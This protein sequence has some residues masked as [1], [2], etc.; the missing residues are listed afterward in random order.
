[1][2]CAHGNVVA[3]VALQVVHMPVPLSG[4]QRR[5]RCRVNHLQ[6]GRVVPTCCHL[7]GWMEQRELHPTTGLRLAADGLRELQP[8]NGGGAETFREFLS[9]PGH[10]GLDLTGSRET[11]PSR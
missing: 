5:Q 10:L 2:I 1:M 8:R 3:T 9:A 4:P 11:V 7:Y 6:V